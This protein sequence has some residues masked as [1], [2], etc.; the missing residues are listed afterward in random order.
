M[1]RGRSV[2]RAENSS[3][4]RTP[5]TSRKRARTVSSSRSKTPVRSKTK[6]GVYVSGPRGGRKKY[7]LKNKKLARA[8]K[9]IARNTLMEDHALGVYSKQITYDASVVEV[10]GQRDFHMT[11]MYRANEHISPHT[12]FSCQWE[13]FTP[14][15]IV[16]AASVLF[17]GKTKAHNYEDDTTNLPLID[18]RFDVPYMSYSIDIYNYNYMSYDVKLYEVSY[19]D[20]T[21]AS[22]RTTAAACLDKQRWVGGAPLFTQTPI[23]V[24]T[25][26]NFDVTMIEGASKHFKFKLVKRKLLKIG[27]KI[28][29]F[30]KHGP[31]QFDAQ[32]Y[33]NDSGNLASHSKMTKAFVLRVTPV[34][35]ISTSDTGKVT[36]SRTTGNSGQNTGWVGEIKEIYKINQPTVSLPSGFN[37][38]TAGDARALFVD[39][40]R[41][42]G[43]TVND[44]FADNG[45][46]KFSAIVY[47]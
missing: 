41:I 6:T 36:G 18:L 1:E 22:W 16:D 46:T 19:K 10:A 47:A 45:P 35:H 38:F 28:S 3:Y 31:F 30:V 26:L 33:L 14:K 42:S 7:K 44:F 17:Y 12:Q 32:H 29:H 40:P 23:G 43:T 39:V 15:K 24:E 20:N 2:A 11:G 4:L 8:V 21:D 9:I 37:S 5:S 13:A 27:D 25:D 34:L